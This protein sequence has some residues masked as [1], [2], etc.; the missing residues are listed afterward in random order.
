MH[1][2]ERFALLLLLSLSLGTALPAQ[3]P[4]DTSLAERLERAEEMIELLRQQMGDQASAAVVPRSRYRVELSGMVLSNFYRTNGPTSAPDA[5]ILVQAPP[6][7]GAPRPQNIGATARQ[8]NIALTGFASDILGGEL[9]GEIEVDFW[10][11]HNFEGRLSPTLRIRRTRAQ[12]DWANAWLL[13]G[14]E[15]P[16]ISTLN[17]VSIAEVGWPGFSAGGNLWFWIPQVRVGATTSG[18]IRFAAEMA[19]LAPTFGGGSGVNIQPNAAERSERPFV[20]GRGMIRWGEDDMVSEVSA[21]LHNGWIAD[22]DSLLLSRAFGAS[23]RVHLTRYLELRAEFFDGQALGTLGGGAQ[24]RNLGAGSVPVRT[25][26]GWGQINVMPIPTVQF[27][28]GFG[29][30]DPND[31]DIAANSIQRNSSW[32]YHVQWRPMP[33]VV[34]LELRDHTTWYGDPAIGRQDLRHVNLGFG[35]AF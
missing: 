30:D 35:F 22:G 13:V 23:A 31:A 25:Y 16:P 8:T 20:Q 32:Q 9:T 29:A 34:G 28:V 11:G 21:G 24:G 14:Q 10:G 5:P 2:P 18:R 26:G 19:A 15:A 3:E 33:V 12:L 27:G 17:P 1:R 4:A 7:P 6:A